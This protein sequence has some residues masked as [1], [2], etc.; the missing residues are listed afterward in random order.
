LT[1]IPGIDVLTKS[2]QWTEIRVVDNKPLLAA[3][4]QARVP[5]LHA[6]KIMG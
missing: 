3:L 4:E 1:G 2:G 5:V 6:V